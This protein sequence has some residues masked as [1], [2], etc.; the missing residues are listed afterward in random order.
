MAQTKVNL[1]DGTQEVI[2]HPD[3]ASEEDILAFAKQQFDAGVF[4]NRDPRQVNAPR[5]ID[6]IQGFGEAAIT[7]GTGMFAE[8]A[9][10]I[11][12][13]SA[14]VEAFIRGEDDP[15]F[16]AEEMISK[17]SQDRTFSPRSQEGRDVLRMLGIPFEKFTTFADEQGQKVLDSKGSPAAAA[18]VETLIVSAPD[19]IGFKGA[20]LRTRK[21]QAEQ[22]LE[23]Q[24]QD[25]GF[26]L[27]AS[28]DVQKQQL[29]SEA[30][31]QVGGRVVKGSGV[32]EIQAAVQSAKEKQKAFVNSLYDDA[33]NMNA[34]IDVTQAVQY[35]DLARQSLADFD[36]E[37]M[38]I[39]QRRL[40]ELDQ[41]SEFPPDSAIRLQK[42]E[43]WRKRLNRNQP[44][45]NDL[46]QQ[47]ALGILKGQLDEFLDAQFNA[48]MIRGTPEALGKWKE[49]RAA[50]SAYQE[51]FKADK[52][53]RQLAEQNANAETIRAWMFGSAKL[54]F[55]KESGSVI[56]R[57]KEIVGED[58]PQFTALRQDAL[59]NIL[60]P[61]LG[62][63]PNF[64]QFIRVYDDL[65]KNRPT[66]ADELFPNSKTSLEEIRKF[67]GAV[68]KHKSPP[69]LLK[70]EETISRALVGH[71]IAK[72]A[73]RVTLL[74]NLLKLMRRAGGKTQR[75]RVMGEILG[76][77]P[78]API[79]PL[80]PALIGGAVQTLAEEE[81]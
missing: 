34:G 22:A 80:T 66:L 25:I 48:D 18:A 69:L 70:L 44:P 60:D 43:D 23:A 10:G 76:Y 14:G 51:R 13:I 24:A 46:A 47:A 2:N 7:V 52:V 71:Q 32:D 33:R 9:A 27:G 72:A 50:S 64:N 11:G 1:P 29:V 36:V 5:D 53:I 4:R 17:I 16:F 6:L 26:D 73:I 12:G 19:A 61:L 81:E 67:A 54:G 8:I 63:T 78:G 58:S 3:G 31:S 49:A 55:S 15:L 75:T 79:I 38:P 30:S 45:S 65:I 74:G 37:A 21:R 57:L 62:E 68:E 39:V 40:S 59:L 35:R 42:I 41:I 20:R 56:S 77:D 28:P